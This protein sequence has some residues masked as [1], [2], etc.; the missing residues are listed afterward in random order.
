MPQGSLRIYQ[1]FTC[2]GA[3]Q[4]VFLDVYAWRMGDRSP[5]GRLVG[6]YTFSQMGKH[7]P[8]KVAL[9]LMRIERAGRF[10]MGVGGGWHAFDAAGEC[11]FIWI[12][13]GLAGMVAIAKGGG[14]DGV[15]GG[16]VVVGGDGGRDG[17]DGD[18]V[19]SAGVL[20][21]GE[22]AVE[23]DEEG[24]AEESAGLRHGDAGE[25][26][27][28]RF[29]RAGFFGGVAVVGGDD[30]G[31]WGGVDGEL[32]VC[33]GV[34]VLSVIAGMASL[35]PGGAVVRE[36]MLLAAVT[37]ALKEAG[38]GKD[39]AFVLAAVVAGLQ[40]LFQIVAEVVMGVGG[41][42]V[43]GGRGIQS[44][45]FRIQSEGIESLSDRGIGSLMVQDCDRVRI[46][47]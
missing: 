27:V 10:G 45:E 32:V 39:E 20:W 9:L 1:N 7:I 6:A 42:V 33:G 4:D 28:G 44:W 34:C 40:R 31:A 3:G 8:G 16:G 11:G 2:G 19:L 25:G 18:G 17:G 23:T 29:F 46:L 37:L 47:R 35:L 30:G 24:G 41:M 38:V 43:T 13:G 21:I 15:A 14:A 36:A 5:T 26:V 12:S 22:S